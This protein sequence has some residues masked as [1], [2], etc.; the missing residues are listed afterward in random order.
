M[1]WPVPDPFHERSMDPLPKEISDIV[2][3]LCRQ[4]DRFA[5]MEQYDDALEKYSQAWNLLPQ[6][7][8]QWP[9]ATWIL[10]S[11]GDAHFRLGEFSDAIELFEDALNF[12]G[13][14]GHPYLILRFGQCLMELGQLDQAAEVLEQAYRDGGDPLFHDE[15]PKYLGL[16]KTRTLHPGKPARRFNHP[17]S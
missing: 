2:D 16:V 4:G 5:E 17:L 11:A 7:P 15:D 6:P 12:P 1:D 8:Q 3:T 13:G 9:A 14:D 10:M